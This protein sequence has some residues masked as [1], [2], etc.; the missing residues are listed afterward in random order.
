[1]HSINTAKSERL[2]GD[3]I[4]ATWRASHNALRTTA[5]AVAERMRV[6]MPMSYRTQI[7]CELVDAAQYARTY[8]E[9]DAHCLDALRVAGD[10]YFHLDNE[11]YCQELTAQI[12]SLR[13]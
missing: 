12:A 5:A 8:D 9:G 2:H 7:V 10:A 3:T 11:L 4:I 1:M 13:V 6:I